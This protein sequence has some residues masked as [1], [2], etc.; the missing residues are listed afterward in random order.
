[1]MLKSIQ[2]AALGLFATS[3]TASVIS[4]VYAVVSTTKNEPVVADEPVVAKEE[5]AT[6][7]VQRYRD[8]RRDSWDRPYRRSRRYRRFRRF[9]RNKYGRYPYSG[10]RYKRYR[11]SRRFRRRNR[12]CFY[13]VRYNRFGDRYRVRVCPY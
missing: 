7:V 10:R 1:M 11:H 2:F 12:R 5:N 6:L 4:P 13:R 9:R 8:Y 3:L